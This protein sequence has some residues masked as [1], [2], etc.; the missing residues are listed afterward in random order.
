[1]L[2]RAET[3]EAR[4]MKGKKLSPDKELGGDKDKAQETGSSTSLD[5]DGMRAYLAYMMDTYGDKGLAAMGD[6]HDREAFDRHDE[7]LH[8]GQHHGIRAVR[9]RQLYNDIRDMLERHNEP[10]Q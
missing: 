6:N 4:G 9:L 5:F 10:L 3:P 7:L 2:G 1:L 8:G